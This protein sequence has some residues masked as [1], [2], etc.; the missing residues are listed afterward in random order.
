M[1][2]GARSRSGPA[3]DPMALRRNRD[4]DDWVTLP[5]DGR[6]GDP[7][8]WPFADQ[9]AREMK[10]WSDLWKLPQA[11]EW[12]KIP[13]VA[14]DVALHTRKWAEAEKPGASTELAKLVR[15]QR[16]DLGLSQSG[17][18]RMRWKIGRR[19]DPDEK[20][21]KKAP[22]KKQAPRKS[23]RGRLHVVTDGG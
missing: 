8:S 23:A 3:P 15:M 10:L 13:G 18:A 5:W 22:A 19:P 11:T 6:A 14:L 2:G 7:P 4:G 1:Q 16:E 21:S 17:L 12:E 20:P 9:T